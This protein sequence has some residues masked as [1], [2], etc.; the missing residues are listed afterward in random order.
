MSCTYEK[1]LVQASDHLRVIAELYNFFTMQEALQ[2]LLSDEVIGT[3]F[4][5]G[6]SIC[7]GL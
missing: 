3:L 5:V 1:K 2:R 7:S 6:V 4:L